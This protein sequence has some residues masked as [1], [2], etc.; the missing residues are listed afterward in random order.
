MSKLLPVRGEWFVAIPVNTLYREYIRSGKEKINF[1]IHLNVLLYVSLFICIL[2][3]R[4]NKFVIKLCV[5]YF[6]ND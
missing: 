6:S 3:N 5:S 4:E 1:C 2:Y